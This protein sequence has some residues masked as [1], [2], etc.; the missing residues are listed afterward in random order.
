MSERK[1]Q[2]KHAITAV[3]LAVALAGGS[4]QGT[5]SV[6]CPAGKHAVP[7]ANGFRCERY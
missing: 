3:L 1:I 4:C 7:A 5:S 2:M 6:G